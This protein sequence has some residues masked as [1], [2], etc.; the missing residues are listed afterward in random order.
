MKKKTIL[1]IA[2]VQT[3]LA[4]CAIPVTSAT[5]PVPTQQ[6][7]L[8]ATPTMTPAPTA[9]DTFTP[10]PT[11]TGTPDQP[12]LNL[13]AQSAILIDADSGE[14]LYQKNPHQ[15]I[16]PASTTKIMT[17]LLAVENLDLRESLVIGDDVNQAWYKSRLDSQKAGLQY[18]EPIQVSELLYALLLPSGSDAAFVI[19][20]AVARKV[21]DDPWMGVD[22]AIQVFIN[23]MNRR[24]ILLGAMDTH[25]V[26]PDGYQ[27]PQH[28]STAYDMALIAQA[29]MQNEAFRQVVASYHYDRASRF[30][31]NSPL[32]WDSTNHLIDPR[33]TEYYP[34]ANGIKTGTSEEAGHCLVSSA[35]FSGR[36]VIAVV[37]KS[38]TPGVWQDSI[39]LLDYA[40][41]LSQAAH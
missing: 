34:D 16:Y 6:P 22:D 3:F 13:A 28:V 14:V 37:F 2:I 4:G 18:N 1:V 26:N 7:S 32:S 39:L 29:A 35:D 10:A 41:S 15:I 36:E 25:F 31:E 20:G 24:A 11:P 30:N 38:T 5:Q 17:A 27:D 23:L 12:D 9:T 40:R 33:A 8:T 21:S 19:A